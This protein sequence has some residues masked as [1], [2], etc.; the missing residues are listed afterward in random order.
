VEEQT[1]AGPEDDV[2]AVRPVT[3][4]A[5]DKDGTRWWAGRRSVVAS[6]LVLLLLAGAG[7]AWQL[8]RGL[9]HDVAFEVGGE[10]TTVADVRDRA[11]TLRALYG[12]QIPNDGKERD[13][14]WRDVAQSMVIGDVLAQQ[15]EER[16]TKVPTEKL[17][18]SLASYLE[19]TFGKGEQ[20]RSAYLSALSNA[21]TSDREVRA[22]IERQLVIA[23]LFDDVTDSV[24]PPSDAEVADSFDR[25]RCYF[26]RP[27]RRKLSNIVV[28]TRSDANAVL[29]DLQQGRPF[30]TVAR[31]RSADQTTAAKGGDLGTHA[32]AEL[33]PGYADAAF[34]ADVGAP[35][36]PV[37]TEDG[38]NIGVVRK[39]V[40][41]EPAVYERVADK[42]AELELSEVKLD[43]WREWLQSV[44]K[45]ASVEYADAY[46]P[47]HPE[48][49]PEAV[50]Q[51]PDGS[52][53]MECS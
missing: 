37:R 39:V 4:V 17:D 25:W 3:V 19:S 16:Q 33:E 13:Q 2:N 40:A 15:A 27:E 11:S 32:A 34:A 35:F 26:D 9:P 36:G 20:G 31:D 10:Q 12:V 48:Q 5:V 49:L 14:Y 46:R 52:E 41:A 18:T 45:G 24:A 43:A 53:A 50:E 44:L 6:A 42:V 28:L 21:G 23:A 22:E 8:N 38:W 1:E 30:A 47:A 51:T 29:D 7:V